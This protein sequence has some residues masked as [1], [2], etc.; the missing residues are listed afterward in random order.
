[1][2]I[3]TAYAAA[4]V[5]VLATGT[6]A[7]GI[8]HVPDD[9]PSIK[10]AIAASA[11]TDTVLVAP[12]TYTGP[13]NLSIIIEDRQFVLRSEGGPENTV[14]DGGGASYAFM[15]SGIPS[16]ALLQGF[17]IR[18]CSY[19]TGGAVRFGSDVNLVIRDCW[20]RDNTTEG[21]GGSAVY[22]VS[23]TSAAFE[24]CVFEG[25]QGCAV[26]LDNAGSVE[27][28]FETCSFIENSGGAIYCNSY[29]RISLVECLFED[30]ATTA[31]GGAVECNS[32]GTSVAAT[33]CSF[34]GNSAGMDG[35]AIDAYC[36]AIRLEDC[37][38]AENDAGQHGGA[39]CGWR[40][41]DVDGSTFVENHAASAGGGLWILGAHSPA[42][43]NCTLVGNASPLG[44]GIWV[45]DPTLLIEGSLIAF[46]TEGAAVSL[47]P[48]AQ[49]HLSC[50]DLYGNS[51][52]DWT[53]A[54]ADQLGLNGN[55][56]EDPLFCMET[57]SLS[58]WTLQ[59]DS[60]CAPGNSGGCGLIGAWPVDCTPTLVESRSWGQIK[61]LYR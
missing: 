23:A 44:S 61:A 22:S 48:G 32:F 27:V 2:K 36:G 19:T 49:V 51:G 8:I 58:P 33:E 3:G 47:D 14:I 57:S 15:L 54:I 53:G 56:S 50:C 34:H 55:I 29:T 21:S 52:G 9:Y 12:G 18:N 40:G 26:Y 5:V 28:R 42:L 59:S 35:G 17:T 45:E 37:I 38:L 31:F 30:N 60:P 11:E 46:S 4:L 25:N 16:T 7:G 13:D 39:I 20:F 6:A 43:T 1:M 41:V 10:K 24:E